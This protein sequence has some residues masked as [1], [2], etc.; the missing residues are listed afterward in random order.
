MFYIFNPVGKL[1]YQDYLVRA[2]F[3]DLTTTNGREVNNGNYIVVT[4]NKT[5]ESRIKQ[6]FTIVK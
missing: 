3:W 6:V 1:I 4:N 2:G 5:G